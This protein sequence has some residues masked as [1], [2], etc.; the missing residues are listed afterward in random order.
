MFKLC[1][2]V[3]GEPVVLLVGGKSSRARGERQPFSFGEFEQ[4]RP[5]QPIV[6]K[7]AVNVGADHIAIGAEGSVAVRADLLGA[8][9][10]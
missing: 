2:H 8:L 6:V 10:D 1:S 7:Q 5:A 9:F 3:S 4:Y